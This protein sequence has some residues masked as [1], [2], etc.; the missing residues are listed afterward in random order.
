MLA[1]G[2]DDL[3]KLPL[4]MRKASLAQILSRPTD[5]IF[6]STFEQGEIG[7][8]LFQHACK[9]RLEGIVSKRVDSWYR[10]G[11]SPLW[12]K[13]KNPDHPAMRRGENWNKAR[14]V[15]AEH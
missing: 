1:S 6:I 8:A 2:G 12:L 10:A 5:G 13:V 9:L 4:S 3:R 7:P 14:G 11:T 15:T